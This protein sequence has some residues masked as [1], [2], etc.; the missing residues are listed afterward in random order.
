ML[1]DTTTQSG[2]DIVIVPQ[3]PEIRSCAE[4]SYNDLYHYEETDESLHS[5]TSK[6]PTP[7]PTE[8]AAFDS[9]NFD[10]ARDV[11]GSISSGSSIRQSSSDNLITRDPR[12]GAFTFAVHGEYDMLL[13]V[14]RSM[15]KCRGKTAE[16][17]ADAVKL[18]KAI[19]KSIDEY[20]VKEQWMYHVGNTKGLA[21]G[22]FLRSALDLFVQNGSVKERK[23]ICVELGTYCGYSAL[24][25]T[26][27]LLQFV[28]E[29]P[30]TPPIEFKIF[31]TEIS[32]NF[33]NVSQSIFRMAKVDAHITPIIIKE[34]TGE[35]ISDVMKQYDISHIDFL[36]LDHAKD[37]YLPDLTNL[38]SRGL[39]KQGSH[40]GADNVVFNRLDSYR[41]HMLALKEQ[42]V[43]DSRLEEMNL[44]YSNNLKDGI[45]MTCYRKDPP[46]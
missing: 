22:R 9:S 5:S 8:D 29:H 40:V 28:S 19:M 18:A 4:V 43:V 10:T 13:H 20:C 21:I 11:T 39:I 7:S 32:T 33:V 41:Q 42:G 45:E 46:I 24:V 14:Q 3:Q 31:T 36:L 23:F 35:N 2:E 15:D 17:G 37:R 34:S 1:F 12:H 26:S 6:P 27:T 38:E 16:G 30:T 44:E 25:L